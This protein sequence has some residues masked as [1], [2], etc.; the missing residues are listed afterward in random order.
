MDLLHERLIDI[1]TVLDDVCR[2][3]GLKY[4]LIGGC[5]IGSLRNGKFIPWDDDVDIAMP[6]KDFDTFRSGVQNGEIVLPASLRVV[7]VLNFV[8]VY[9]TNYKVVCEN[10][11]VQCRNLK[12]DYIGP[13]V[14]IFPLDGVPRGRLLRKIY[15]SV[16][17]NIVG[18]STGLYIC[19]SRPR[20][21]LKTVVCSLLK[22]VLPIPFLVSLTEHIVHA[23]DYEDSDEVY[24]FFDAHRPR[25]KI[26]KGG[27]GDGK[28][29]TLEG[30]VFSTFFSAEEWLQNVYGRW[31]IPEASTKETPIIIPVDE[32]RQETLSR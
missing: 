25:E 23:F 18:L 16:L 32:L 8:K 20:V 19:S 2:K 4:Y 14:D 28:S 31:E 21:S 6:R 26:T 22:L 3:N 1:L 10:A 11:A 5:L 27:I 30:H 9:D 17:C 15:V 24:N 7:N 29:V 12:L 13:W